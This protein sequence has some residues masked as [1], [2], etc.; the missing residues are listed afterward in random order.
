MPAVPF[1]CP[2]GER[3]AGELAVELVAPGPSLELGVYSLDLEM[4]IADRDE[5]LRASVSVDVAPP[6]DLKKKTF[7]CMDFG[8][9]ESGAAILKGGGP[10]D[11]PSRIALGRVGFVTDDEIVVDAESFLPTVAAASCGHGVQDKIDWSFGEDALRKIAAFDHARGSLS[12][13][14]NL[15]WGLG[16]DTSEP[17]PNGD[18]ITVSQIASLYLAHLLDRM[19]THPMYAE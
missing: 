5:P 19:E 18:R 12:V 15:K 8:T 2:S 1:V 10:H 11:L 17:L 7:I 9:T 6:S 14:Q 3:I 13:F 16:S 4:Q